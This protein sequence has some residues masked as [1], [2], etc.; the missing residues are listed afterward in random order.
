VCFKHHFHTM[1]Q[2]G[3]SDAR[4]LRLRSHTTAVIGVMDNFFSFSQGEVILTKE[5]LNV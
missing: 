1:D 2:P 3:W 5:L 4:S